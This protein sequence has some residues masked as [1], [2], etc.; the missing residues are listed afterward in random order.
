M[1]TKPE[2][3][4]WWWIPL[5]KRLV[6]S[7]G[8]LILCVTAVNGT[9]QTQTLTNCTEAALRAAMAGGGTVIF[10]CDGTITLT[11]SITIQHNTVLDG[12]GHQVTISGGDAVRVFCNSTNT[13]L[14]LLNLTI[15]NGRCTNGA[16]IFND[17]GIVSLSNICLET[18]VAYINGAGS[19]LGSEGGAIYNRAGTLNATN[20][21]FFGNAAA[22]PPQYFGPWE[23][24]G[25]AIRN[26]SGTI[27]LKSCAFAGNSACG[28]IVG[29]PG[30]SW[31][32]PGAGGVGGAIYNDN[33]ASLT[34]SGCKFSGNSASGGPGFSSPPGRY[35]NS[36]GSGTGGAI[37][38]SGVMEVDDCTFSQNSGIGAAGGS[39]T[40]S[41]G[42][43]N[44]GSGEGGGIFNSGSLVVQS[45]AFL[46]NTVCGGSGGN[47]GPNVTYPFTGLAGGTGGSGSGG[48]ICNLGSL[49][50]QSSTFAGNAAAGAG[51]GRAGDG[52]P[53]STGSGAAPGGTGGLGGSG[54]G[55]ALFNSG[56]VSLVNST[57]VT[58]LG[59]GSSGGGGGTGGSSFNAPHYP[60]GAN[61]GN[62]GTGGSGFGGVYVESGSVKITNGT[63]AYNLGTLGQGGSGGQGGSSDHY[64]GS[65]GIP[66]ANGIAA[67]GIRALG[68]LTLN[69]ILAGNSPSN[70][71]GSIT[72]AGHNL[73]SDNSCAFTGAG[74]LNN[75]D[76]MLGP[77][78]DN[79]GPTLTMAL[80]PGSPAI[81]AGD[82]A[83][84]P[85]TDQR[86][87]A[88]PVGAASDI[89]AYECSAPFVTTISPS[90]TVERGSGVNLWISTVG[91]P[92]SG[93][94]WFCNATN[95]VACGT[96]CWCELTNCDFP[97][98]G[99]YIVIISNIFGAVTSAPVMLNVIPPVE[100]RPVPGVRVTGEVGSVLNVEYSASFTP[101]SNW[102]PLDTV[103]LTNPPQYW[104][105]LTTPLPPQRFYRAWQMAT[106]AVV[107]SLNLHFLP[108]I[109]LTGNIGDKLGLDC[110]NQI[111]P[112]DAWVT[113][114]TVTLTNTSQLYFDTSAIGQP[115]RLYRIV[116]V[117]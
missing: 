36:G 93:Y 98:S 117:P 81:D 47:A 89:G 29:T 5:G 76:P 8:A 2:F 14:S 1:K 102:L 4:N 56:T 97:Q 41:G 26:E 85:P 58:N 38:N 34:A 108:A 48:G 67:G 77:L 24:R 7:T 66:G 63:I 53:A 82:D 111:G 61:G 22:P 101:G 31:N 33:G 11:D 114:D 104:F 71:I 59:S 17:G 16:G 32:E 3:K 46:D 115:T 105:D 103:N 35:P 49:F 52:V 42:N 62:G 15:S 37:F 92:A 107:P 9:A 106:P 113:L 75:V 69:T 51:G 70:C 57:L 100:R 54:Y 20:C 21:N 109:T 112:T 12:S 23:A 50:L 45:N 95:L 73:S 25:G 74:S 28:G 13:S 91:D 60:D 83:A 78:A 27:S 64:P 110:I 44:G 55:G 99:T 30:D 43:F 40:W 10:A 39:C 116:P 87:V 90:Q 80:L 19:F 84:A 68:S 86:G 96:N 94:L 88:R 18:N 79:G 65:P 6:L 72:D